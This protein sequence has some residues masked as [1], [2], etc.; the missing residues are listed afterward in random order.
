MELVLDFG[1]SYQ[2]IAL[3]DHGEMIRMD[4]STHTTVSRIREFVSGSPGITASILSSVIPY[5]VSIRKFLGSGFSF[6]ELNEDTPLPIINRYQSPAS[7]GHDRLAAAVAG[8]NA[9]RGENVLVIILG[10]A[11]T[12]NIITEKGEFLGG[13]ISPGMNMR[14]RAL[15][16]F[17]GKLPLITF[18]EVRDPVGRNTEESL[19]SG[20]I[21]GIT[22]EVEG[23]T[24]MYRK[25]FPGLKTVIS[26][27]DLNY[28]DKRLKISIFAIPNIVLN[29]LHQILEFNVEKFT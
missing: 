14:F 23:I 7:L 6:L 29:G 10:S 25:K 22:A 21:N 17:T 8:F 3:F 28:F 1:N 9:F 5:P 20:V 11:I 19:L 13:A 16:T 2:K 12:F 24:E 18:N 26:G 4:Q 15:H 27:G